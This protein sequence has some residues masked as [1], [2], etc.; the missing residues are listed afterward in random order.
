[1][2]AI[3][4]R[5]RQEI[6]RGD[7]I[8][9]P[10]GQALDIEPEVDLIA[11]RYDGPPPDHF[12]ERFIQTWG[13]EHLAAQLAPVRSAEGVRHVIPAG[14]VRHRLSYAVTD[15]DRRPGSRETGLAVDIV[16]GLEG[17]S[18]VVSI[19][20]DL[21][22]LGPSRAVAIWPGARYRLAGGTAVGILTLE[23]ELM[24]EARRTG[25]IALSRRPPSPEYA[26][27]AR[28]DGPVERLEID[29]AS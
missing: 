8:V 26:P 3:A 21:V 28:G 2:T 16:F 1:M 5:R 19:G 15:A 25:Y 29:S 12:R 7:A 27:E 24:H 22:R 13:F 20:A 18:A 14:D 10:Q 11:V 4:G 17:D 6:A 23:T 9:V